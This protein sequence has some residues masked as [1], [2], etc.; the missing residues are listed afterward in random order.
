MYI[1]Y[2]NS[3]AK[4]YVLICIMQRKVTLNIIN[5][6]YNSNRMHNIYTVINISMS[7]YT[8]SI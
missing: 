1:H 4:T 5:I 3:P 7:F 8:C 6:I 2:K